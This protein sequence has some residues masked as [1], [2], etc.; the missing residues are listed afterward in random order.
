VTTDVKGYDLIKQLV[1]TP[2]NP[3]F[4]HSLALKFHSG[5]KL[6]SKTGVL[7]IEEPSTS[8]VT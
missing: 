5:L 8:T 3:E 7:L 2:K 6:R 4:T 1:N